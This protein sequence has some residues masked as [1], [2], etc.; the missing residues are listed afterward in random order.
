MNFPT[1]QAVEEAINWLRVL[2]DPRA[3]K[4]T[5]CEPKY[6]K[7]AELAIEVL[8]SLP[9]LRQNAE[10]WDNHISRCVRPLTPPTK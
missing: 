9:S 1:P 6:K 5:L 4:C 10:A 3:C 8:Q 7:S 2:C